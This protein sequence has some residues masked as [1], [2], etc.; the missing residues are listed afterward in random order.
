MDKNK[1]PIVKK[2][3]GKYFGETAEEKKMRFRIFSHN[4]E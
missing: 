2:R 3:R 4:S 1:K